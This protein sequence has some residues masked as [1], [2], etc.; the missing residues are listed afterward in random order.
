MCFSIVLKYCIYY[1][2]T[3]IMLIYYK[4][5]W[6]KSLYVTELCDLSFLQV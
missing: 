6:L 5:H 4:Y 2:T 1:E 3:E